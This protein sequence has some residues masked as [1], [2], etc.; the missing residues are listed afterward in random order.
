MRQVPDIQ[1]VDIRTKE[2][3]RGV[4]FASRC[5]VKKVTPLCSF[6]NYCERSV[7]MLKNVKLLKTSFR[8]LSETKNLVLCG[9]MAGLGIVLGYVATI[10]VGQYIRIGFSM[11]PNRIIDF[12]FGPVAGGIFGGVLDIL[13]YFLTPAGSSGSFF[14]GFT[15]SSILTGILYGFILY[16]KPLTLSRVIV[17]EVLEKVLIDLIL[18]TIW[19]SILYGT[20]FWVNLF[21]TGRIVAKLI[22][23]PVDIV[24]VFVLLG[25]MQKILVQLKFVSGYKEA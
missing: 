14:P 13:K 12:A 15:L 11:I 1:G 20:P 10:Q 3:F 2:Y 25:V 4:A 7:F 24:I 23:L 16:K 18:N 5:Y 17:A 6:R 19:L 8:E 9:L 22:Q 21:G